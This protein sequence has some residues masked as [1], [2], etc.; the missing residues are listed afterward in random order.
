MTP[1]DVSCARPGAVSPPR[2]ERVDATTAALRTAILG[3]HLLLHD[4][5]RAA[6]LGL[7]DAPGTG[8]TSADEAA[9]APAL[10]RAVLAELGGSSAAIAADPL[11][12]GLLCEWAAVAAPHL[13]PVLTGHLDLTVGAI[14]A[15]GNGSDYQRELAA[16]L[17]DGSALGVLALT[18]L[19]GTNGADQQTTAT[20][21]PTLDGFRLDSPTVGSWKF[22]PNIAFPSARI[23]IVTARLIVDGADEGVL[24]FLLR[25][26]HRDG[27]PVPGLRVRALPDK[28]WAPM[29]HAMI[30]FDAV[31]VPREALLGGDWAVPGPD[32]R[33]RC[34]LAP[35]ARWHRAIGMLGE[36]RLDLAVAATAAARAGVAVL[37]HYSRVRQ[38]GSIAMADR[39]TVRRDLVSALAS[40]TATGVLGRRIQELRTRAHTA[41][42]EHALWAMLA[43]PLLACTAHEVLTTCRRRGAAQASLRVN[44]IGDWLGI[45]E[46]IITAEGESQILLKQAGSALAAGATVALGRLPDEPWYLGLLAERERVLTDGLRDG[47]FR[48]AGT[49]IDRDTAAVDLATATGERLAAGAVFAASRATTDGRA[50]AILESVAAVYALER[51][52]DRACWYVANGR[53]SAGRSRVVEATLLGHHDALAGRIDDLVGAFDIPLAELDAPMASADYLTWWQDWAARPGSATGSAAGELSWE[54]RG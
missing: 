41:R 28:P 39:G 45:V 31:F 21:D 13:L 23:G 27:T 26:R 46:G 7:G 48:V 44:R 17:D 14:A 49:A 8:A 6:V 4:R 43:K 33:L 42:P 22:M 47:D 34:A 1:V 38:P 36:G 9:R 52:H 2:P 18:E 10:L 5:V 11:V 51:I 25:F 40:V 20:W 54:V 37:H 35:R 16:E 32:G 29:D 12:R 30:R 3:P 24:P 15:L 50:R 53:L 19:G